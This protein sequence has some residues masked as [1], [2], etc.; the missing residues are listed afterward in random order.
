MNPDCTRDP[1]T[2]VPALELHTRPGYINTRIL[3]GLM[4]IAI[5]FYIL[6]LYCKDKTPKK[7][8]KQKEKQKNKKKKLQNKT[9]PIPN[10]VARLIP[11]QTKHNIPLS[12]RF[13][14]LQPHWPK[15]TGLGYINLIKSKG[16]SCV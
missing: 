1:G 8:N 15:E 14:A 10:Q 6:R 3:P 4:K 7:A 16:I 9:K 11:N 5:R 12:V 13:D 2:R